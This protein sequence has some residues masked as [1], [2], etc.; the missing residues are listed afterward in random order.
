MSPGRI[1]A[2]AAIV[3][4]LHALGDG[5]DVVELRCRR[6]FD[7]EACL[8]Y[9]DPMLATWC[10]SPLSLARVD[11]GRLLPVSQRWVVESVHVGMVV[12]SASYE[13]K[14]GAR[15]TY[16]LASSRFLSQRPRPFLKDE[17]HS[18]VGV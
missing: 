2:R 3:G 12:G 9:F 5:L 8:D 15:A 1:R 18:S 16:R 10:R 6:R 17:Q 13:W 14:I 7:R 4:R 11:A